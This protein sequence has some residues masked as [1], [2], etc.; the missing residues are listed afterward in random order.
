MGNDYTTQNKQSVLE[1]A[2]VDMT[3]EA[4]DYLKNPE[5]FRSFGEGLAELIGKKGYSG[6]S[7]NIVAMSEYL[8]AKLEKIHSSIKK[9]T[10][11]SWFSGKHSPKVEAA[12]RPKM[13]EIC[14]SL[15]LT[16]DETVWF[17]HHVYYDRAFN[18]HMIEEAVF[19]YAFLNGISYQKAQEIISEIEAAP[20]AVADHNIEPNYTSIVRNRILEIHSDAEL[21]EFLISNKENFEN[22]NVSASK[23]LHD[24]VS[25]LLG[26]P[27]IKV[28]IDALKR[29]L[30]R[31]AESKLD[32]GIQNLH[33]VGGELYQGCGLLMKEIFY[34]AEYPDEEYGNAR[35]TP[36][37]SLMELIGNRNISTYTFLLE[38]LLTTSSGLKKKNEIPYIVRNNFPSK[39]VISDLLS[40]DKIYTSKSY[41]GIRK[42]LVLLDFYRFWLNIKL[43]IGYTELTAEELFKTYCD[44]A[45]SCLDECGYEKLYDGNPYDWIFLTAANSEAPIV[46]LRSCITEL[47]DVL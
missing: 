34:D 6:D 25:G 16:Y 37:E 24:L 29:Q 10:V 45:N 36:V 18:C 28:R 33:L 31:Q 2:C 41:D 19:Y 17:F 14:F 47:D 13:Y 3:E 11:V 40:E 42:M 26:Q 32:N 1:Y 9:E 27:E 4:V 22:W 23:K 12:S 38:R 35:R 7:G 30:M 43:K 39:K 15:G 20:T 46:Y 5:S 21:K 44:E 8:M